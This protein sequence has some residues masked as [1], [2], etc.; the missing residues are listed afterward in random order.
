[1]IDKYSNYSIDEFGI[2]HQIEK[3]SFFK[4]YGIERNNYG[5]IS[6]YLSYLRLGFIQSVANNPEYSILD[7]GFGNGDFLKACSKYYKTTAGYDL[8][9]DYLP[10]ESKR[11]NDLFKYYDIITF[12]DSLEHFNNINIISKLDCKYLIISVP[13]CKTFEENWFMNWKHRRPN[14]HLYHFNENSLCQFIISN[15]FEIL[16]I[17]YFEDT[18]RKSEQEKNILTVVAKSNKK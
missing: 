1:M 7:V 3:D 5:E 6:K 8:I 13:N 18:I 14:E 4:D 11:E 12:F 9:Y 16:K 10:K 15:K 17:S 2:I